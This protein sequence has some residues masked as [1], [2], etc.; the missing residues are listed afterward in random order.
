MLF[1][2]LPPFPQL[3]ATPQATSISF[4]T[5]FTQVYPASDRAL[6]MLHTLKKNVRSDDAEVRTGVGAM[7]K[8][9][10]PTLGQESA[11]KRMLVWYPTRQQSCQ[12]MSSGLYDG[13]LS[14]P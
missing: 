2:R 12:L 4:H 11:Y 8:E 5:P 9:Y 3:N 7:R 10:P 13:A 14:L 1:Q 6:G